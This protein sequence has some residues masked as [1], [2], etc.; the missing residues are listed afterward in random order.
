MRE[1]EALV[2]G[3]GPAPAERPRAVK[4]PYLRDLE[5]QLSQAVGTRVTIQPGRAKNTGR[6]VIDYG[7]LD[8]FDRV[9]ALLGAKLES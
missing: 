3:P 9:A 1:L 5:G 7:S 6:V 4:A 8:E 2:A